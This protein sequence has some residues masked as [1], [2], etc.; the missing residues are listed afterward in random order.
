MKASDRVRFLRA[1][2]RNG[3]LVRFEH[4]HEPG[5]QCGFVVGL[6]P[7][8]VAMLRVDDGV[9][10]NGFQCWRIADLRRPE[11]APHAKFTAEALR[12]RGERRPRRP[13]LD[14]SSAR[15]LLRSAGRA[16]PL[17]TIHRH[18][19]AP[20]ECHIGR[21][22]AVQPESM[23]MQCIWPGAVWSTEATRYRLR[24]ITRIDCG[25]IYEHALARVGG[26]PPAL[27]P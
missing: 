27:G 24:D 5:R 9:Q 11:L 16:F 21:V 2:A 8:F 23:T 10:Y 14:L 3:Q 19:I 26:E 7:Q 13:R 17:V 4:T 22:L 18:R 12:L 20:D 15:A 6:G 25:G 1:A